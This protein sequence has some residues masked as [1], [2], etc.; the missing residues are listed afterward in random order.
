MDTSSEHQ[1][2]KN[3]H[4][5][6][7]NTNDKE[8]LAVE[9][10]LLK[11]AIR[12]SP[13]LLKLARTYADAM[14]IMW[15][16]SQ[17]AKNT[18]DEIRDLIKEIYK[19][20]LPN[21]HHYHGVADIIR[22]VFCEEVLGWKLKDDGKYDPQYWQVYPITGERVAPTKFAP[23]F[24]I[25]G[26]IISQLIFKVQNTLSRALKSANTTSNSQVCV[27]NGRSIHNC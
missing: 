24:E 19:K 27:C 26:R 7:N 8:L 14:N 2:Q 1:L 5:L 17:I 4:V 13:K 25:P 6:M 12:G 20:C 10:E 18:A 15:E 22:D 11:N 3:L 16:N 9:R 23:E 21:R